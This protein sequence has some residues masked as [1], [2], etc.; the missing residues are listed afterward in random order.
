MEE[1]FEQIRKE[2]ERQDSK[3]GVQEHDP[4]IW[5]SILGEE[6][7]EVNKAVLE[8]YFDDVDMEEYRKELI[9]VASV[10]VAAI[11]S[12]DNSMDELNNTVNP[13]DIG[14]NIV[15][16]DGDTWLELGIDGWM[17]DDTQYEIITSLNNRYRGYNMEWGFDVEDTDIDT[18]ESNNEKVIL[19]RKL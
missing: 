7:G 15:N 17:E 13:Y 5:T 9:Q 12:L 10:C 19:F 6:V 11:Q 3:F 16:N 2:R 8:N 4:F 14:T 1:I 18:L